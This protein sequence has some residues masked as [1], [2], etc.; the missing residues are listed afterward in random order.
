MLYNSV[1]VEAIKLSVKNLENKN[2]SAKEV[3]LRSIVYLE[4]HYLL[5]EKKE[6]LEKA[7]WH[8]YAYLELGFAYDDGKELFEK[9]V[10]RR[11]PIRQIGYDFSQLVAD[12]QVQGDLFTDYDKLQ[13]EK[14]LVG[15]VLE[16]KDKYGKNSILKG[17][18]FLPGATQRERNKT[19]GGH[20]DGT[21]EDA[22]Q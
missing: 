2:I 16:I 14:S 15:S 6:Y 17:I 3:L 18:D 7:V 10:D 13:K 5:N 21:D 11:K 1:E 22:T 4:K 9:I 19:I 20:S 12:T 8:I